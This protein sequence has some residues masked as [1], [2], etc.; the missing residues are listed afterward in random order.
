MV[1]PSVQSLRDRADQLDQQ[2]RIM[3][4]RLQE[5]IHQLDTMP[6]K[7]GLHDQLVDEE[8]RAMSVARACSSGTS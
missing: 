4:T 3:E 7:P 1:E 2:K 6:G 5:I 8:V